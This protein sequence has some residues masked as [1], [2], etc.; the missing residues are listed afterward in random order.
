MLL[1]VLFFFKVAAISKEE[2]LASSRQMKTGSTKFSK[3]GNG[4]FRVYCASQ[5]LRSMVVS[6]AKTI[7]EKIDLRFHMPSGFN[8]GE[9]ISEMSFKCWLNCHR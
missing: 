5:D 9:A 6:F 3:S 1:Q 8:L 7:Y 2:R 4:N